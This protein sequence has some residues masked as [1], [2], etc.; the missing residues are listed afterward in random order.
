MGMRWFGTC[1]YKAVCSTVLGETH[2]GFSYHQKNTLVNVKLKWVKDN[3][4]DLVV[5]RERDLKAVCTLVSILFSA[6]NCFLPIYRLSRHPCS[7]LHLDS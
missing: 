6:F 2:K 4:L 3:S 5:A 7:L 1:F